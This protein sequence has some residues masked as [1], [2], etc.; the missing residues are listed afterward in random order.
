MTYYPE[1]DLSN[2]ARTGRAYWKLVSVN[3]PLR[4]SRQGQKY[5][6]TLVTATSPEQ[7]S[8]ASDNASHS[9]F[10]LYFTRCHL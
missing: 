5:G 8:L 7:A 4:L 1:C 9:T 3:K 10:E 6:E 2:S